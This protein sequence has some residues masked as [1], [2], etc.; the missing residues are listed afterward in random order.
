MDR[1]SL[2]AT[3]AATGVAGCTNSTPNTGTELDLPEENVYSLGEEAQ[4]EVALLNTRRMKIHSQV[5]YTDRDSAEIATWNPGEDKNI[6]F[7]DYWVENLSNGD[8]DWPD[9]ANFKLTHPEGVSEPIIELPGGESV[10]EIRD[11]TVS[12]PES[13]GL[14][15]DYE[16]GW[17]GVYVAPSVGGDSYAAKWTR[18]EQPFYWTPE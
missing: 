16:R 12:W 15:S 13:T 2:L 17:S 14:R 9:W 11:E 1:R 4:H 6:V 3:I 8:I 5:E 10:E 18:P 7:T